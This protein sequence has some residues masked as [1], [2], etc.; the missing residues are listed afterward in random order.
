MISKADLSE[1]QRLA[2][3]FYDNDKKFVRRIIHGVSLMD[4]DI[5]KLQAENEALKKE[6]AD[7]KLLKK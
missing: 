5:M 4:R 7:L 2:T 6:I 1:L 3:N